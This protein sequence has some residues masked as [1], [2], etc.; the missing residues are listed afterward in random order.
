MDYT[1]SLRLSA[2]TTLELLARKLE[3]RLEEFP[4]SAAS[5]QFWRIRAHADAVLGFTLG[6]AAPGE[7]H[8]ERILE[9]IGELRAAIVAEPA[10]NAIS[11]GAL[12]RLCLV[13]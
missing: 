12:P 1:S 13:S 5:E 8:M 7:W 11:R 2:Y 10:E 4:R 9:A 3:D 6:D